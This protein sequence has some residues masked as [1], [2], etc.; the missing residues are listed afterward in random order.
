MSK[1]SRRGFLG[2]AGGTAAG[3]G[4]AACAGT[5]GSTSTTTSAGGSGG[6]ITLDFWSNHP[7]SS[8]ET[9][10]KIITAFQAANPT[11]KVKLTDAGKNYEEVAQ[12]FNASLA[13]GTKPDL[14]VA[15][16]VTWF[17]FALNGNLAPLDDLFSAAGVQTSDYVDALLSDYLY[18]GKHYALPYAR[19]TPLFYY[20]KAV[21]TKA[22]LPDRGP[23]TWQE[24]LEW[25]PKLAAAGGSSIAPIVLP[26]GSNYLDWY[27][28]NMAWG[29]GGAYSQEWTPKF[30][31]AKTIEAGTFLQGLFSNKYARASASASSDFAAGTA[32]A[33]LE[34]TGSLKTVAK[35]AKFDFG[36]AFLPAPDGVNACPTGGAGVGIPAGIADDRKAAA[37]K[38]LAFLTSPENTVTFTQATG[39]MPTRKS[40][41]DNAA[42]KEYL[43]ANP[44]AKVAVQ[45][46]AVTKSQDNARVFVPGGGKRIGTALDKIAQGASVADTFKALDAETQQVIDAQIKPKLKS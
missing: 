1:V 22:G 3:L 17:N 33:L 16:D 42:E 34:S 32:A 13:G 21:W 36:T 45:Q 15:S 24:F 23:K 29:F 25:A 10:Q 9:E 2:L 46:L 37:M 43:A 28:Q 19:S 20:N 26:D 35:S 38:F 30:S 5:G 6:T 8:K 44:N 7:G 27:F 40:A 11:I 39:Y 31:D 12:K 4:L 18:N 41:L 14:V